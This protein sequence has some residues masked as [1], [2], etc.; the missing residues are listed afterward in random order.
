MGLGVIEPRGQDHVPGTSYVIDDTQRQPEEET[1]GLKYDRSGPVPIVLVPQPSDDPNDPLNWPLWK[2]DA[3]LAILSLVAVICTTMSPILAANTV[4][5]ATSFGE[6]FTDVALLTGYH[7]LGVGVAGFLCVPTARVWGKRH[8]FILG[9]I[10]MIISCAWAGGSSNNF[11]SLQ[12]ARVFQGFALAPFEAL[13]NTCVGDL[14]FVHERGKR[15]ALSNVALFGGAFLTPVFVG[16]ITDSLG[17]EWSFYFVAIFLG[18]LLPVMI[19]F[20]PE[21]AYRR[22]DKL[23]TDFIGDSQVPARGNLQGRPSDSDNTVY[24]PGQMDQEAQA[25]EQTQE[26]PYKNEAGGTEPAASA[27]PQ[28]ATLWQRVQLFNGRKTD[29]KFW[30]LL[31]RPFPLLFLHPGIV[32]ACLIQG[33]MIGWTVLI[34]VVLGVVFLGPPLWFDEVRTGYMYVGAFIGSI[35]GLAISGLLSDWIMKVMVKLNKG[36]YEPEFRIPLVF[37]QMLFCGIGLYGF[38]IVTDDITRYGWFLAEVFFAFVI[39]GMVLGTV[40]SA[41]YVVDAHRQI[42]VEAFTAMLVFKNIF[43]FILCYFAYDWFVARSGTRIPFIIIGSIQIGVCLLSIPM[44]VFGKINRSFFARHDILK[45]LGL[46]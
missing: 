44:Y 35:L 21:T 17:W 15:M 6:S 40:A 38:G 5:I 36:V 19:F 42:A 25:V 8:L 45:M 29:E 18:A 43:S 22:A 10:L 37:F 23:N 7:L 34:G 28:R 9:Q 12:A 2:R 30:K 3:I 32:W 26:T 1:P 41:L 46:W 11:R 20:V 16:K 33:V 24:E 27:A 4:T 31:L 14:Y 13:V 39:M